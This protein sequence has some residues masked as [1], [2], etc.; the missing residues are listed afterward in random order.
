MMLKTS[1]VNTPVNLVPALAISSWGLALGM[2]LLAAYLIFAG[3]EFQE[4]NAALA[5]EHEKL[6]TK[7]A[8]VYDVNKQQLSRERF[9]QLTSRIATINSLTELSG[10]DVSLILSQFER[11][12]PDQTYLL[13]LN[14]RSVTDDIS[15]VIESFEVA[16]LTR[17]IDQLEADSL[18]SNISIVRQDNVKIKNQTAVQFEVHLKSANQVRAY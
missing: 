18:F 3:Q 14:Y 6:Q 16:K 7:W 5:N 2:L 1:F 11:L 4:K 10:L 9:D 8:S 15:L 17:F 12:M 13:S